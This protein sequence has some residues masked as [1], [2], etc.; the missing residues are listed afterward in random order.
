MEDKLIYLLKQEIELLEIMTEEIKNEID[1][2]HKFSPEEIF[3]LS[4]DKNEELENLIFLKGEIEEYTSNSNIDITEDKYEYYTMKLQK[5]TELF[6]TENTKLMVM[7]TSMKKLYDNI[8]EDIDD[9]SIIN[10]DI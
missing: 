8:I 4:N 1:M 6:V 3:Q 9:K 2:F 7:T 10:I 5:I